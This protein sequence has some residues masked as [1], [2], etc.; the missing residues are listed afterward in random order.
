MHDT[1]STSY[2]LDLTDLKAFCEPHLA[3][4]EKV[5]Q[6]LCSAAVIF[7]DRWLSCL[8]SALPNDQM[9][10]CVRACARACVRVFVSV[11]LSLCVCDGWKARTEHLRK[12]LAECIA[13]FWLLPDSAQC[14]PLLCKKSW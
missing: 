8:L 5:M 6:K 3:E 14:V 4:V 7:S 12:V 11:C 2:Q 9:R 10:M 13:L 1:N